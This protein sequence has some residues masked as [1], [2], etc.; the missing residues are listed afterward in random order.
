[1]PTFAVPGDQIAAQLGTVASGVMP[2]PVS[3]AATTTIAPTTFLTFV[4]GS[5]TINTLTPPITGTHMLCLIWAQSTTSAITTAGN[6]K[7]ASTVLV[8]LVPNFFV[9]NP[10]EAKYYFAP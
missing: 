3:I 6:I 5:T 8:G 1:M 2:D 9:Y 10:I 7:A 4:V